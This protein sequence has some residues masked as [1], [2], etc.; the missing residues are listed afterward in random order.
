[1]TGYDHATLTLKKII[2]QVR[3]QRIKVGVPTA[4]NEALNRT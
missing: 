3:S 1:M 2:I 4:K